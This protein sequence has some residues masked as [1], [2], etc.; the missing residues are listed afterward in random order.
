[1]KKKA[2]MLRHMQKASFIMLSFFYVPRGIWHTYTAG[3]SMLHLN[4]INMDSWPEQILPSVFLR[5]CV[6]I[7]HSVMMKIG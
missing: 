1:M 3:V 5:I 6:I 4:V 2:W 7:F